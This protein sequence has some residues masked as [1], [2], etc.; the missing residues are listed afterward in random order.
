MNGRAARR[1]NSRASGS[2]VVV[3]TMDRIVGNLVLTGLLTSAT[4]QA[5]DV[6]GRVYDTLKGEIYK[7]AR[8]ELDARPP[9]HTTTD[10]FGQYWFRGIEPGAYLIRIR[11]VGHKEVVGRLVVSSKAPTTIGNLDISRIETPHEQDEY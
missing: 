4:A 5:A 11:R 7:N 8:I 2:L 3:R 10:G 6:Y 1:D 9:M